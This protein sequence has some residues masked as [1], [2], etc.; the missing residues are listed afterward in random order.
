VG[1]VAGAAGVHRRA[2]RGWCIDAPK[3]KRTVG[4]PTAEFMTHTGPL[5]IERLVET[6]Q[7]RFVFRRSTIVG[8]SRRLAFSRDRCA[9]VTCSQLIWFVTIGG[10]TRC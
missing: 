3:C 10:M 5:Y 2:S 6:K 7:G 1:A 4:L 8:G 9:R